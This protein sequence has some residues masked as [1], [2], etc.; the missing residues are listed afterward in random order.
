MKKKQRSRERSLLFSVLLSYVT[1]SKTS[2]TLEFWW[3]L[4]GKFLGNFV[5]STYIDF[6]H[7]TQ[8]PPKIFLK[9]SVNPKTTSHRRG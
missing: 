8:F 5:S 9:D 2:Q 4:L 3:W 7:V 6:Y 1:L